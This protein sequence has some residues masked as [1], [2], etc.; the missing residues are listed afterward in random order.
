[1]S[2]Q[3]SLTLLTAC[4]WCKIFGIWPTGG[5]WICLFNVEMCELRVAFSISYAAWWWSL[6][7]KIPSFQ[8][9]SR[10]NHVLNFAFRS[11]KPSVTKTPASEISS[12]LGRR[13]ERRI[14]RCTSCWARRARAQI[15]VSAT[16]EI[17]V[18]EDPCEGWSSIRASRRCWRVGVVCKQKL[19]DQR[20]NFCFTSCELYHDNR[21][22]KIKYESFQ[23][24]M[25][26]DLF[27]EI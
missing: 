14:H 21:S 8:E 17:C 7:F 20:S 24:S 18:W 1:M 12:S 3:S 11:R 5:I 25:F 19:V 26:D 2:W 13:R 16:P 4:R 15:D 22:V 9:W 10:S 23:I 6:V 27:I